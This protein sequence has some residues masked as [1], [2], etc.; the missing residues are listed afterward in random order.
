[1][2]RLLCGKSV[3]VYIFELHIDFFISTMLKR[4]E[5]RSSF[6]LSVCESAFA[7]AFVQERQYTK[8]LSKIL[9]F[10]SRS[11]LEHR[12]HY[13]QRNTLLSPLENVYSAWEPDTSNNNG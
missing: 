10:S 2:A 3:Q 13:Q 11:M 5:D 7:L 9:S 4:T 6:N 12:L 1:M 8:L